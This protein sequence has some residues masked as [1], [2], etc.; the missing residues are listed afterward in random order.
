MRKIIALTLA[1]VMC[2]ALVA[3][4]S[5]NTPTV[6]NDGNGVT[7]NQLHWNRSDAHSNDDGT[8]DAITTKEGITLT[9]D[10]DHRFLISDKDESYWSYIV[11]PYDQLNLKVEGG[12]IISLVYYGY[13]GLPLG[14]Y[15]DETSWTLA[16]GEP[17]DDV[18]VPATDKNGET[19]VDVIMT[20]SNAEGQL[21]VAYLN[22]ADIGG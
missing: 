16:I 1:L 14:G 10:N 8:F 9:S 7:F 5:G 20:I 22:R 18:M 11:Y 4:G 6:D 17:T 12:K 2:L 15:F 19:I 3:C 13:D 21:F